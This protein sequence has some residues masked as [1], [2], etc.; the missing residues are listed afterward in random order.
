MPVPK[1]VR[2]VSSD[3]VAPRA[4]PV[5]SD[6]SRGA[7]VP[8]P[9]RPPSPPAGKTQDPPP[10]RT[11]R[12][13]TP[14]PRKGTAVPSGTIFDS[15]PGAPPAAHPDAGGH[16]RTTFGSVTKT[17]R[18]GSTQAIRTGPKADNKTRF[19]KHMVRG[20]DRVAIRDDIP[21]AFR[22]LSSAGPE[23]YPDTHR[24]WLIDLSLSG[25][26]VEGPLPEDPPRQA[27][28][29]G[30]VLVRL[31]VEL[32]FVDEPLVIDSR[33]TWVKPASEASS[34]IGLEFA[35]VT[36]QQMNTI[37]AFFIGLQSPARTKF[38]RGRPDGPP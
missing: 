20:E 25:A 18:P 16:T 13:R 38:R 11:V 7:P 1:P 2:R 30:A 3:G 4:T 37:R 27:L 23:L 28:L 36:Q 32:P 12:P 31:K 21:V 33:L 24:G 19:T 14:V 15:K 10:P 26:Q 17:T 6:A 35:S 5:P 34:L 9:V 22:F 29:S 8:R